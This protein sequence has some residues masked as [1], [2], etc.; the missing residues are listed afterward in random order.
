M[1]PSKIVN[2]ETPNW[3][4]SQY[5]NALFQKPAAAI[6]EIQTLHLR[7][8]IARPGIN[9]PVDMTAPDQSGFFGQ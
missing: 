8:L 1:I 9:T 2:R 6:D 5:Y 3:L 4:I 7:G